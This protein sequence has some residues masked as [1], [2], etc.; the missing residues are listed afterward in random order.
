MICLKQTLRYLVFALTFISAPLWGKTELPVLPATLAVQGLSLH[1]DP[2]Q[3]VFDENKGFSGV[4]TVFFPA[5]GRELSVTYANVRLDG[6]AHWQS[7]NIKASIAPDLLKAAAMGNIASPNFVGNFNGLKNFI[8]TARS[9]TDELPLMLNNLPSYQKANFGTLAVMLTEINVSDNGT[10]VAMMA[11]ERMPEGIYLPFTRTDVAFDPLNPQS[12]KETQLALTATA[13][14]ADP[15]MP[16]TFKAGD[17]AGTKGTYVTFDCNGLK[18][19]HVE[20]FHKFTSGIITPSPATAPPVVAEFSADVKSLRQFVVKVTL[21]KFTIAGFDD[22]GFEIKDATIDYSDSENPTTLPEAYFKEMGNTAPTKRETWKGIHIGNLTISL[23]SLPMKDK[24]GNAFAFGGKDMIYD[25]GNGFSTT[26]YAKTAGFA[27][28][29]IKGF[30]LVLDEFNLR[31]KKSSVQELN[32]LGSLAIPVL[33]DEKGALQYKA[34][35]NTSGDTTQSKF[36]VAVQFPQDL[37]LQVPLLELAGCKLQKTSV[38]K[39]YSKSNKWNVFANLQGNFNIGLKK[40]S[41]VSL[42]LPFEGWKIGDDPLVQTQSGAEELP[43]NFKAFDLKGDSSSSAPPKK[44][45]GFPLSIDSISFK[46]EKG[47]YIFGMQV[48]VALGSGSSSFQAKGGIDISANLQFA[49]LISKKPW[50]G[51]AFK[52]VTLKSL[53]VDADMSAFR[54]NG[55]L[56]LMNND[57]VYGNGFNADLTLKVKVGSKGGFSVDAKAIF[58]RKDNYSYFYVDANGTL[59]APVVLA[60]PLMLNSFGGGIYYNM[61]R[62]ASS[63]GKSYKFIPNGTSFG[64]IA[65]V[66]VNMTKRE[67]FDGIGQMTIQFGSNWEFQSFDIKLDAGVLN[68]LSKINFLASNPYAESSKIYGNITLRYDNVKKYISLDGRV[69]LSIPTMLISGEATLAMFF[70]LQDASNWYVRFGTT[71]NNARVK[72]GPATVGMYLMMGKGVGG[73]LPS[74]AERVPDLATM[75]ALSGPALQ[76]LDP[77]NSRPTSDNATG[78]GFAF[79]INYSMK[80]NFKVLIFSGGVEAAFGVDALLRDGLVCENGEKRGWN[81]WYMKGQAYAYLGARIGLYVNLFFVKGE[82][83]IAKLKIGAVLQAELPDPIFLSGRV[84]GSYYILGGLVSGKFSFGLE[85]TKEVKP[86]CELQRKKAEP[87]SPAVG[88]AII[89]ATSPEKGDLIQVFDDIN[90]ATNLA[91]QGNQTYEFTDDEGVTKTYFYSVRLVRVDIMSKDSTKTF[92]TINTANLLYKDENTLV[93]TPNMALPANTDL[94]LV[95]TAEA[96]DTGEKGDTLKK[97]GTETRTVEFKTGDRPNKVYAPM[98]SYAAPGQDQKYWY[99]GYATAKVS[100]KQNGYEYLFETNYNGVES[101]YK[102]R[103]YKKQGADSTFTLI[104]TYKLWPP[105]QGEDYVFLTND[106]CFRCGS[107]KSPTGVYIVNE[108][109]VCTYSIPVPSRSFTFNGSYANGL[110]VKGLDEMD[111]EKQATYRIEVI[112][113]PKNLN[114]QK[115]TAVTKVESTQVEGLDAD[116]E[117]K[118]TTRSLS[119]TKATGVQEIAII[120]T[121]TFSISQVTNLADKIAISATPQTESVKGLGQP[122]VFDTDNLVGR[123]SGGSRPYLTVVGT[124]EPLDKYD[125]GRILAFGTLSQS[126]GTEFHKRT[127]ER[128]TQFQGFNGITEAFL[129]ANDIHNF[130]SGNDRIFNGLVMNASVDNFIRSGK[131]GLELVFNSVN[132]QWSRSE[133]MRS[134]AKSVRLNYKSE[135]S[136]FTNEW[137]DRFVGSTSAPSLQAYNPGD[138]KITGKLMYKTPTY[139]PDNFNVDPSRGDFNTNGQHRFRDYEF[140]FTPPRR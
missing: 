34:T 92:T 77:N 54:F 35:F 137:I 1:I 132:V 136:Q 36:E 139:T 14:V 62:Q 69:I 89:A 25:K 2:Q 61:E 108:C 13:D 120:Y 87:V 10:T 121:N 99:K 44:M 79:G 75:G 7:G 95:I 39:I 59:P 133:L 116:N 60:A 86:S 131:N 40:E 11:L 41:I 71:V 123:V 28:V 33:L 91:I 17:A 76:R 138:W 115:A 126:L 113:Q 80:Q 135:R 127:N 96:Y 140:S 8:K 124:I 27:D 48:G 74:I 19:F 47:V 105:F 52:D 3:S 94:K 114:I 21:P 82:F 22:I 125:M 90:V 98:V 111:L 97:I 100:L 134:S 38:I 56:M 63:D 85:V 88:R 58:G 93:L 12:F 30:R 72:W 29:N 37:E 73:T 43:M 81:G 24:D 49:K 57:P 130:Q 103:L 65:R 84:A 109:N 31:L 20:G 23:P 78:S 51:I 42:G 102:W 9:N 6:Q 26:L 70:D 55:Q 66:G 68:D 110:Y 83:T 32:F 107:K 5:L 46:T 101:E 106:N 53:K 64:L 15:Q 117:V 128:L 4:G 18:V 45:S 67:S 119:V 50:E 16:I 129:M 122:D 118:L 112:R 104:G